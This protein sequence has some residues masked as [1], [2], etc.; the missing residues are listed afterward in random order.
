MAQHNAL[1]LDPATPYVLES[2]RGDHYCGDRAAWRAILVNLSLMA[3][4]PVRSLLTIFIGCS[5]IYRKTQ[6]TP[7]PSQCSRARALYRD[8][9]K[10]D[11]KNK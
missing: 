3:L 1:S 11:N 7:A 5:H 9:C 2:S 6:F 4:L 10:S 8:L